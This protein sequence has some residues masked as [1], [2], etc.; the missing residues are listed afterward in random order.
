MNGHSKERSLLLHLKQ[1]IDELTMAEPTSTPSTLPSSR[2]GVKEISLASL[3][4]CD[5]PLNA[6]VETLNALIKDWFPA[7]TLPQH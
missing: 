1:R 4:V 7:E 5:V 2:R 6:F 3:L